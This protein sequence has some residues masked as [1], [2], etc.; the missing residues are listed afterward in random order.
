MQH[1]QWV[2]NRTKKKKK[3][4]FQNFQLKTCSFLFKC[5]QQY[6]FE[7]YFNCR[8]QNNLQLNDVNRKQCLIDYVNRKT[9][10]DLAREYWIFPNHIA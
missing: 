10:F 2:K 3:K 7:L 6:F 1:Y 9:E 8:F 4:A 5:G